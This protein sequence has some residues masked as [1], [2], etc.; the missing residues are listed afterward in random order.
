MRNRKSFSVNIITA[1]RSL[2]M[3]RIAL[4]CKLHAIQNL[5]NWL[6]SNIN[7]PTRQQNKIPNYNHNQND[8][9]LGHQTLP[10][11]PLQNQNFRQIL[12]QKVRP[13]FSVLSLNQDAIFQ[14]AV[15]LK[16]FLESNSWIFRTC[17]FAL[18][19]SGTHVFQG[20]FVNYIKFLLHNQAFHD[21]KN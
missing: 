17:N 11:L 3:I 16:A 2:Y 12:S 21:K 13:K 9:F 5:Q 15:L 1:C 6:E 8:H 14:L 19:W 18:F 20:D 10:L 4:H 7:F